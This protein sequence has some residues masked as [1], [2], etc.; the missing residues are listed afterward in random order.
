M[1]IILSKPYTNA[2]ITVPESTFAN[3]RNDKEI[4]TAISLIILIGAQI[5]SHG[6]SGEHMPTQ[7]S[8]AL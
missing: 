6:G 1:A 3:K 8:F 4:G 7:M 2:M 5:G